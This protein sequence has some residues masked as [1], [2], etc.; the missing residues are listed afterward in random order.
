MAIR[1]FV[2]LLV[3]ILR[4]YSEAKEG[5]RRQSHRA[6]EQLEGTEFPRDGAPL[7]FIGGLVAERPSE[8]AP[9]PLTQLIDRTYLRPVKPV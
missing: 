8:E 3:F 2:C 1:L 5:S 7:P 6:R 4:S 9:L